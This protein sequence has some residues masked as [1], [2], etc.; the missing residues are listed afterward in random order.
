VNHGALEHLAEA[1]QHVAQGQERIQKQR[2]IIADLERDGHDTGQASA[3]LKTL[4][5][6][7]ALH[8]QRRDRALRELG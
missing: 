2:A 4:L 3:L 5:N 8:E 7:Q 1:Q 6:I